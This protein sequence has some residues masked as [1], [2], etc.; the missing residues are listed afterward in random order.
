VERRGWK[1]SIALLAATALVATACGGSDAP[2][3]APTPAPAPAPAPTPTDE[4][5][6]FSDLAPITL[7]LSTIVGP[8]ANMSQLQVWF[9]DELEARTDGKVKYEMNYGASLLGATEFL[10]GVVEG[11]AEGGLLVPAYH[12]REL[13][14]T[15]LIM[16][17]AQG[18]NQGARPRAMQYMLDNSAV[19]EE[20]TNN[21]FFVIGMTPNSSQTAVITKPVSTVEEYNGLRMRVAGIPGL[22]YSQVGVEPLFLSAAEVYE[23]IQRGIVD[24]VTFPWETHW[25][26]GTHEVGKYIVQD[27]LGESGMALHV[28]SLNTWNSLDPRV[29]NVIRELQTEW[30]DKLEE[31]MIRIDNEACDAYIANGNEIIIFSDAEKAK[32]SAATSEIMFNKWLNDAVDAGVPEAQVRDIWATYSAKVLEFNQVTSYVDAPVACKARMG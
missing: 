25:S 32:L 3:A 28:L 18:H 20:V 29:Q 2:A 16:V 22:G 24:G 10:S 13:A 31:I 5:V 27:G 6:D 30:Y 12:P 23:A 7:R 19:G 15:N 8:A 14:L 26:Q 21:G 9:H 11:R 1:T 17:P 4:E